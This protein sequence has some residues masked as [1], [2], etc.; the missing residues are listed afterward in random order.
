MRDEVRI[1]RIIFHK[2]YRKGISRIAKDFIIAL[3]QVA[4]EKTLT[5]R[6]AL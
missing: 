5:A 1:E 3:L 4:P 6:D 2:R